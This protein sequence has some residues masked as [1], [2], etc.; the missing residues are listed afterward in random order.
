V[1]AEGGVRVLIGTGGATPIISPV[2]SCLFS[3][4]AGAGSSCA[5]KYNAVVASR[6]KLSVWSLCDR[7]CFRTEGRL[8]GFWSAGLS[9]EKSS[10]AALFS[11]SYS[12]SRGR[13]LK[14]RVGAVDVRDF[15]GP[16]SD[17]TGDVLGDANF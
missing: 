9:S 10:C 4:F 11:R 12:V 6:L 1:N 8:C 5:A 7:R 17:R 16:N 2:F 14:I 13:E 3:P 15:V